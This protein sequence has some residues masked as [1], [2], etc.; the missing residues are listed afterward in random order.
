[1]CH[2]IVWVAPWWH[3]NG[4]NK[5]QKFTT[6]LFASMFFTYCVITCLLF[7]E[8]CLGDRDVPKPFWTLVH[9]VLLL[10]I[11]HLAHLIPPSWLVHFPVT[12]TAYSSRTF[13]WCILQQWLLILL[14]PLTVH[15][16]NYFLPLHQRVRHT[17][18][19]INLQM[20]HIK[21]TTYLGENHT[22]SQTEVTFKH[23]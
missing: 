10:T 13:P 4:F 2:R 6:V 23:S 5:F 16:R 18:V 14:H 1:M 15:P 22:T 8:W 9:W 19:F 11:V 20:H 3:E 7:Q 17:C 21:N 12:I